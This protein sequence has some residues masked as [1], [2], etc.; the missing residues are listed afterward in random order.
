MWGKHLF[1]GGFAQYPQGR[2]DSWWGKAGAPQETCPQLSG[3]CHRG[4]SRK[5]TAAPQGGIDLLSLLSV[6]L[7]STYN[8][9]LFPVFREV[10]VAGFS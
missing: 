5:G 6:T 1:C 2:F 9:A 8:T 3:I 7:V 10:R 4:P